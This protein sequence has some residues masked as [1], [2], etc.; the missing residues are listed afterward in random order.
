MKISNR[1]L[2][3]KVAPS[4]P[5]QTKKTGGDICGLPTVRVVGIGPIKEGRPKDHG[6]A[7]FT[8]CAMCDC[9]GPTPKEK[10]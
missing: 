8:I 4:G 9:I 6:S 1:Y 10:V 3:V 2:K 7:N 5:C